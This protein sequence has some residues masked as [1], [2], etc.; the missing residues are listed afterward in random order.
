MVGRFSAVA[1][2]S[3]TPK[4]TIF[5]FAGHEERKRRGLELYR[6]GLAPSIILSV[7]RF[8]W[9]RFAALGLPDDGGLTRLV[10]TI[11]PPKRHFFVHLES[12]RATCRAVPKGRFGTLS[13]ARALAEELAIS[14]I[15]DAWI[16]SSEPHLPRCLLAIRMCLRSPCRLHPVSTGSERSGRW[17]EALKLAGYLAISP[18]VRLRTIA[19][20]HKSALA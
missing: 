20:K 19:R 12:D 9:R 8:E 10:E 4:G 14:Q 6:E 3:A 15:H 2:A 18:L 16:L 11:D 13:E 7:A 5:V 17:V 1:T